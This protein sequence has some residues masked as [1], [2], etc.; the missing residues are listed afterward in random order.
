MTISTLISNDNNKNFER[1]NVSFKSAPQNPNLT[2]T[3]SMLSRDGDKMPDFDA[4]SKTIQEM[5]TTSVTILKSIKDSSDTLDKLQLSITKSFRSLSKELT[6]SRTNFG[7]MLSGVGGSKTSAAGVAGMGTGA[8]ADFPETKK[9]EEP[10]K[11][12]D[13]K[14]SLLDLASNAIDFAGVGGAI[15][16]AGSFL[17]RAASGPLLLPAAVGGVVAGLAAHRAEAQKADPLGA[18]NFDR[19][20][21]SGAKRA[22]VIQGPE[23]DK[24]APNANADISRKKLSPPDFLMREGIIKMP[25]EAK[26]VIASIKGDIITLKDGRWWDNKEQILKNPNGDPTKGGD[27]SENYKDLP[28]S[29]KKYWQLNNPD[30][31]VMYGK[32]SADDRKQANKLVSTASTQEAEKFI[33]EKF[34]GSASRLERLKEIK[35]DQTPPPTSQSQTDSQPQPQPMTGEGDETAPEVT[36]NFS[37]DVDA[38]VK[39]KNERNKNNS[40]FKPVTKKS[41]DPN[42]VSNEPS[43]DAYASGKD[44][45]PKTGPAIV[46]EEGPELVMSKDGS[47]RVTGSGA[48]V[49]KLKKGDSVLPADETKEA[50]PGVAE[51]APA[52]KSGALPTGLTGYAKGTKATPKND[53]GELMLDSDWQPYLDKEKHAR[54]IGGSSDTMSDDE[55]NEYE[56]FKS[57]K[58]YG[59]K[60][61]MWDEKVAHPNAEAAAQ[62]YTSDRGDAEE[63]DV[64]AKLQRGERVDPDKPPGTMTKRELASRIQ[65]YGM[66]ALAS[67][68]YTPEEFQRITRAAGQ[69]Q[70]QTDAEDKYRAAK[71]AKNQPGEVK[72]LGAPT[73]MEGYAEG[74][75]NAT[76]EWKKLSKSEKQSLLHIDQKNKKEGGEKR[77]IEELLQLKSHPDYGSRVDQYEKKNAGDKNFGDFGSIDP[78][79]IQE[80]EGRINDYASALGEKDPEKRK[81][82]MNA[83]YEQQ[84][85][86]Y[87]ALSKAISEMGPSKPWSQEDADKA[88]ESM[89]GKGAPEK[90]PDAG[91]SGDAP[92]GGDAGGAGAPA[93]SADSGGA[94]APSSGGGD[95][96]G[97]SGDSVGTP[98]GAATSTVP[99]APPETPK[100]ETSNQ[101]VVINNEQTTNS[102]SSS[103]GEAL[104]TPNFPMTAQNDALTQYFQK[105]MLKEH[106]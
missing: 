80:S 1:P 86:A 34:P 4:W 19:T 97:D 75:D 3:S 36:N 70:W 69:F 91:A 16:S 63:W 22:E 53:T 76:D 43:P 41:I 64:Q 58:Q 29:T 96:G 28:D 82:M 102:D 15:K 8:A 7:K 101:P 59:G 61:S 93:A 37:D 32:L 55:R 60:D 9:T 95:S 100:P 78:K 104:S 87:E 65:Q 62:G 90:A 35:A 44:Y 83:Y 73:K 13:N 79:L 99:P 77:S 26:N 71:Q 11:T 38:A 85:K 18:E 88:I 68:A 30:I 10:K 12:E 33:T 47:A 94:E 2:K 39:A 84:K 103:G 57:K 45:V 6:S 52:D 14:S 81:D 48:H 31:L 17:A 51:K 92:S 23:A 50:L 27:I 42:A 66:P 24:N 98:A 54:Y 89:K 105:Q 25:S 20:T 40:V 56:G 106:N 5:N 74:T 46:G 49:E 67:G 21:A 72:P